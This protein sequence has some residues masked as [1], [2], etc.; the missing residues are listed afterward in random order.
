VPPKCFTIGPNI[1]I[2]LSY[3]I[4]IIFLA[5]LF[6]IVWF[7][8]LFSTIYICRLVSRITEFKRQLKKMIQSLAIFSCMYLGESAWA[9]IL[10][11]NSCETTIVKEDNE[12]TKKITKC[13]SDSEEEGPMLLA[14]VY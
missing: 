1:N 5:L 9:Y 6:L 10:M 2:G 3:A 11:N 8:L 12:E 7:E 13:G 14:L 4:T